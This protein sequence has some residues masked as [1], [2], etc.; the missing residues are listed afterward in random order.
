MKK[1]TIL[2]IL[3]NYL[4][5]NSYSQTSVPK[6]EVKLI[7]FTNSTASFIVPKG[8]VWYIMNVITNYSFGKDDDNPNIYIKS[9]NGKE[10]TNVSQKK[11]GPRIYCYNSSL[12][13]EK[14]LILPENTQIEFLI[15]LNGVPLK[16]SAYINYIEVAK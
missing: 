4:N 13:I 2:L 7:E 9:I 1:I 10:L 12:S 5:F 14:P 15:S 6:G 3:I 8:K 11:Y 16:L